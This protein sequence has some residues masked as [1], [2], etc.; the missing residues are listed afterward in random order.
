[1]NFP[2]GGRCPLCPEPRTEDWKCVCPDHGLVEVNWRVDSDLMRS[3]CKVCGSECLMVVGDDETLRWFLTKCGLPSKYRKI[4]D[5]W[6]DEGD[7][8]NGSTHP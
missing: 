1:M 5:E 8:Y 3:Y 2:K 4:D 7:S 6:L